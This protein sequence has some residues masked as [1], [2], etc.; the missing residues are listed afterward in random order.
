[1]DRRGLKTTV[2]LRKKV[3]DAHHIGKRL[4]QNNPIIDCHQDIAHR[5]E[6]FDLFNSSEI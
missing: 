1:M 3:D 4:F 2:N 6:G 5:N